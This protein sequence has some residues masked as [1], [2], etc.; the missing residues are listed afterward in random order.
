VFRQD[1]T[2]LSVARQ[3]R[4]AGVLAPVDGII[5]AV[6]PEVRRH[7]EVIHQYPYEEGWLFV[8]APTR[9]KPNLEKLLYG[10]K[11]LAWIHYESHRLLGLL[12]STTG[13]TLPDGGTMVN[14]VYRSFPGLGW[15]TLVKE[16][17][18]SR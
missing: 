6:N 15:D 14:D 10:E 5:E 16:F 7:P 1:T 17:L 18:R 9:L 11:N 8:V 3:G 12:E 13:A 4:P 2:G